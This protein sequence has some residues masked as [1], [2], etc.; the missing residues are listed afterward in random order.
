MVLTET[1]VLLDC[2][3]DFGSVISRVPVADWFSAEM[4]I[5]GVPVSDTEPVANE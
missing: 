3:E 1:V 5:E 4:L 2:V